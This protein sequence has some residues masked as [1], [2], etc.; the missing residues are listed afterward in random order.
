MSINKDLLIFLPKERKRP[1]K[2]IKIFT[3]GSR[4][5]VINHKWIHITPSQHQWWKKAIGPPAMIQPL[6]LQMS[7]SVHLHCTCASAG[8][9][10]PH[11]RTS[12]KAFLRHVCSAGLKSWRMR[13][14]RTPRRSWART[15]PGSRWASTQIQQTGGCKSSRPGQ[16]RR[17]LKGL[18]LRTL[19]RAG[20]SLIT[21][22]TVRH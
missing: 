20:G 11:I 10:Q 15:A 7:Y 14:S 13:R 3:V 19:G 6:S 21:F 18:G 17:Y 4:K 2:K 8:P 5:V 16:T 9:W 22:T 1:V 12:S